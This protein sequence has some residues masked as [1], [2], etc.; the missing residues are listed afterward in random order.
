MTTPRFATTFA[1]LAAA[2]LA[3]VPLGAAGDDQVV[4]DPELFALI[5]AGEFIMG[6]AADHVKDVT[7]HPVKVSAFY[8]QKKE[9]TLS[10]W[11]E[12]RTWGLE[13]GY[14]AMTA[15]V[16]KA[17]EHPV[18]SVSWYDVVKWCNALSEKDGLTP[19]YY[20]DAEQTEV[21][22]TGVTPL[23]AT[24]VK[25]NASGYRLPTEAEWEKAARG[26]LAGKRFPWG[27]TIS[28]SQA[29]FRNGGAEL[30]QTGGT[31]YHPGSVNGTPPYTLPVGS[32]AANDYG[33]YDMTGNVWEW[34]WDWFGPYPATL[35]TD[36]RGPGE[37]TLRIG[38]GGSWSINA[39]YCRV[40]NRIIG[41]PGGV[42]VNIGF[43]PVRG[44]TVS[45][46]E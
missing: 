28:H 25:W 38:R 33:L 4:P 22:R 35:H 41:Y 31:G 45:D 17:A 24:M 11:N 34:C 14:T 15:G 19:C 30:Y 46:G 37:G 9:V 42:S 23:D 29:N 8:M 2:L 43:R 18:H 5:P 7:P 26:G 3:G 20:T 6:D 40:A 12:V 32:F 36:P 44:A 21:Y 13:H 16:G 27:D 1:A 39:Y 10:D